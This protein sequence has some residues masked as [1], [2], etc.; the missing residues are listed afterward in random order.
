MQKATYQQHPT[1]LIVKLNLRLYNVL[2][3]AIYYNVTFGKES[4]VLKCSAKYK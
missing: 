4:A 3:T 2:G 1:N